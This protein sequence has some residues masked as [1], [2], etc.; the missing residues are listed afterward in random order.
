MRTSLR[1][2]KLLLLPLLA[3]FCVIPAQMF[4]ATRVYFNDFSNGSSSLANWST[5]RIPGCVGDFDIGVTNG[6]LQ[7]TLGT[8]EPTGAYAAIHCANFLSPYS[9]TLRN[10]PGLVVWA[11]NLSNQ[12]GEF[13][14]DFAFRVAANNDAPGYVSGYVFEGGGLLG[15]RMALFRE[16]YP[17][18]G[19][20]AY[21]PIIDIQVGLGTLP[22]I[23][24]FKIT[25]DPRTSLWSLYGVMG[26]AAVNPEEVDTLLGS[27]VDDTLTGV[28]LP[29][30]SLS[31][32]TTG[33]DRVDNISVLVVPQPCFLC[34]TN[35]M[36]CNDHG[37]CGAIVDYTSPAAT[38]CNGGVITCVPPPGS[39]F[40]VGTNLVVCTA[41]EPPPG[42]LT[43]TCAFLVTVSDCEPPSIQSIVASPAILWPPNHR[44]QPVTLSVSATDNCHVARTRIV[45][46]TSNEPGPSPDWELTGDLTLNLRA[47]RSG[48][49]AGRLY[50]I[51][52]E[53]A[54][55]SG[56]TSTAVATV[57]VPH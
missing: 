6:Q 1:N 53:C 57:A 47:E 12:D 40:P 45:G 17:P 24:S 48:K 20:P 25:F 55:D 13:N 54:D 16:T 44:M 43:N 33:F 56:N 3:I 23:G 38:N 18:V 28:P 30:M 50:S 21:V 22:D 4:S 31:G 35:M 14:N 9:S 15:N 8:P 5:G 19:D 52:V 29:W 37:Q 39:F 26:T 2:P 11:F 27:A 32:L 46:V 49:G 34:P 41:V 51:T 7:I 36:V 10:N 42:Q